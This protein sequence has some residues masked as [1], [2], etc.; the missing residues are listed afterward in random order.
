[1]APSVQ[2]DGWGREAESRKGEG[3]VEERA[4]ADIHFERKAKCIRFH[5]ECETLPPHPLHPSLSLPFCTKGPVNRTAGN[6]H[7]A[8][9]GVYP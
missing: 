2:K 7:L 8:F 6:P 5:F 4:Y 9:Q 3:G 1:M